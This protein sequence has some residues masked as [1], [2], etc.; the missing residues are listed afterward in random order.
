MRFKYES[1]PSNGVVISPS[2]KLTMECHSTVPTAWVCME[3]PANWRILL[4]ARFT[5]GTL[6][7][8]SLRFSSGPG[9]S[10]L[11]NGSRRQEGWHRGPKSH[12]SS[13]FR[14]MHRG[15]SGESS[16]TA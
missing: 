3:F 10:G 13:C 4:D 11:P 8:Q 15:R 6:N 1:T 12:L 16:V 2:E 5:R 9:K 7:E 14:D